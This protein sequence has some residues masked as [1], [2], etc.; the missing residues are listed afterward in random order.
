M[1]YSD[2]WYF[3]RAFN[4][5]VIFAIR[6]GDPA[7]CA[8]SMYTRSV[9]NIPATKTLY[10]KI[11]WIYTY[12]KNAA[13]LSN[14]CSRMKKY[15]VT[16]VRTELKLQKRKKIIP[17]EKRTGNGISWQ[18]SYYIGRKETDESNTYWD[19]FNDTDIKENFIIH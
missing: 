4:T 10:L 19:F 7:G 12:N 1:S 3:S 11:I 15:S 6:W 2:V 14:F 5:T 18:L 9:R 13:N 17:F 8:M 16:P